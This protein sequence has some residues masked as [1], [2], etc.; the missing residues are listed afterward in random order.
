LSGVYARK[1]GAGRADLAV[2]TAVPAVGGLF[3]L[4]AGLSNYSREFI[5]L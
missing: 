2:S 3:P 4:V 1:D 5:G